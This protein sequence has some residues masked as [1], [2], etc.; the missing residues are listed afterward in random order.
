MMRSAAVKP[1]P[2][3]RTGPDAS[4]LPGGGRR[5][6]R[7]LRNGGGC[8]RMLKMPLARTSLRH[9]ICSGAIWKPSPAGSRVI[10]DIDV[11]VRMLSAMPTAAGYLARYSATTFL[12][13]LMSSGSGSPL[14]ACQW[15]ANV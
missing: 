9:D 1:E 12:V 4:V 8:R 3:I 7:M 10:E 13:G 2:T 11:E 15:F 6:L 5:V 14:T